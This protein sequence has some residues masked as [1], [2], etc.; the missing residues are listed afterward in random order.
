MKIAV[1]GLGSFGYA[2]LYHLDQ[3]NTDHSIQA[4]DVRPAIVQSIQTTRCHP[5]LG[6]ESKL[7][8][9]IQVS[10]DLTNTVISAD[11]IFLCVASSGIESVLEM[12]KPYIL[13]KVAIINTAKSLD[14]QGRLISQTVREVLT[15]FHGQY[16]VLSGATKAQD[17]MSGRF[18]SATFASEYQELISTIESLLRS[19]NFHLETTMDVDTTEIAGIAKNSITL[20]YG[21]MQ[22]YGYSETQVEYVLARAMREIESLKPSL[23]DTPLMPAWNVDVLVSAH[24]DTRNVVFGRK[25]GRSLLKKELFVPSD[26]TI[27]IEGWSTLETLPAHEI[28]SQSSILVNLRKLLVTKDISHTKWEEQVFSE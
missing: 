10:E 24:S 5:D 2:M 17:L 3:Q 25:I 27:T 11:L 26:T 7:S 9:K 1:L 15:P 18:V 6:S 22:G 12:L 13:P 19:P 28:L 21:F 20:L 4:W 16:G 14:T 23:M 8:D